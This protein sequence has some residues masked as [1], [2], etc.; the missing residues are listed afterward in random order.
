M[1]DHDGTALLPVR[2]EW[3]EFRDVGEGVCHITEPAVHPFLRSNL[4]YLEG[5]QRPLLVDAGLGVGDLP[6]ALSARG[7]VEPQV[8]VTHAHLDHMGGAHGFVDVWSHRAES[9]ALADPEADSLVTRRLPP[10]FQQALA[11]GEPDG[12]PPDYLI[13]AVPSEGFRPDDYVL[14]ASPPTR[15]LGDGDRVDLGDRVLEVV[16]LP[17]HTP[18]SAALFD[19]DTG[20]LFSGDVVYDDELLDELPES[21]IGD[22]VASMRRLMTL[23]VRTVHAGHEPSFDGDRLLELCEAYLV[24]RG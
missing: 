7:L 23:P 14:R 17:G 22:Y 24:Y 13:D 12:T 21:D 15:E 5:A 20:T 6:A 10:A 2:S 18:G 4:W 9:G 19:R 1:D 3:F 11:S 16:H 8:W